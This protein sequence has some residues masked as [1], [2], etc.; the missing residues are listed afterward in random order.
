VY[1]VLLYHLLS[2]FDAL[3]DAVLQRQLY[4]VTKLIITNFDKWVNGDFQCQI[5]TK[6][7]N[8][9]E[10]QD[11]VEPSNQTI[12]RKKKKRKKKKESWMI[13]DV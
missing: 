11:R 4:I 5:L 13:N 8:K 7:K 2:A 3:R 1:W 6:Y 9:K 10:T 12:Q